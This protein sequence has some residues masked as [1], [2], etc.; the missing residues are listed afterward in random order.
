MA[1]VPD[2]E[3]GANGYV[4][5]R[6]FF[7]YKFSKQQASV[8]CSCCVHGLFRQHC[9][10]TRRW[11]TCRCC[12]RCRK[13]PA[14]LSASNASTCT[15]PPPLQA[16]LAGLSFDEGEFGVCGYITKVRRWAGDEPFLFAG[17]TYALAILVKAAGQADLSGVLVE[18]TLVCT[19]AP[20]VLVSSLHPLRCHALV[21]LC[22]AR[23]QL[24]DVDAAGKLGA[25][26]HLRMEPPASSAATPFTLF[27]HL[28][29]YPPCAP[30][31]RAWM[32]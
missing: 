26:Q 4:S 10:L 16:G 12:R 25:W 19:A 13:A 23:A 22:A 3:G 20:C 32:L 27:L 28:F 29:L 21:F 24:L 18:P 11:L 14:S 2:S 15:R 6:Q 1:H 7:I 31:C 9:T 5:S 30:T 17:H 8:R